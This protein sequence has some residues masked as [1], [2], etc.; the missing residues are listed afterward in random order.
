MIGYVE[1]GGIE[2]RL[3]DGDVSLR[4]SLI[5]VLR[6]IQ[7]PAEW[8]R[9]RGLI[10]Y[11]SPAARVLAL[12]IALEEGDTAW[13]MSELSTDA[14]WP[15]QPTDTALLQFLQPVMSDPAVALALGVP[16]DD[17][18]EN[19]RDVLVRWPP[20]FDDVTPARACT[21]AAC[22]M[23]ASFADTAAEPRLRDLGLI[24]RFSLE[25]RAWADEVTRRAQAGSVM[26]QPA[27]ALIRGVGST[28]MN[29]SRRPLPA[30]DANWRDWLDWA[31]GR[32]PAR[33]ALPNPH[34]QPNRPY[35]QDSHR[36]AIRIHEALTGR[37]V[38]TEL[39][40]A[41]EQATEDSAR[42]VFGGILRGIG[43]LSPSDPDD[44]A[45]QLRT[46]SEAERNLARRELP[47][48][49]R[50]APHAD[51][52]TTFELINH[53]LAMT[54][55]RAPA[56]PTLE[57]PAGTPLTTSPAASDVAMVIISDGLPAAIL[58]RWA[59]RA[60]FVTAA[61]AGALDPRTARRTVSAGN[62]T[63]V[64]SFAV[65]SWS[66]SEWLPRAS[67]QT[68]R[69]YAGGSTYFLLRTESGWVIVSQSAWIT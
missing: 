16:R 38:R 31:D 32:N 34:A 25:P 17:A 47:E 12:D 63:T 41:F 49:M 42:L 23:L 66:F 52:A 27:A 20:E 50:S 29:A 5:S 67:N 36:L 40:A 39:R 9:L 61:E 48:L 18:Y 46:G 37:P 6:R 68:P 11:S 43:E 51:S 54:I 1:P 35:V 10:R 45:R 14:F 7:D 53:V 59:S 58:E 55:E 57:A 44:L 21:P 33:P 62:V 56:W 22:R 30:A 8:Q 4:D 69:G 2:A 64:G 65:V 60:R 15:R 26:L 3:R 24:A 13:V 28:S 19:L